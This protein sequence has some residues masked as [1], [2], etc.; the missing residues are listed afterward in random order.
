MSLRKKTAQGLLFAMGDTLVGRMLNIITSIVL[1]RLIAPDQFGI[2]AIIMVFQAFYQLLIDAGFGQALIQ[3][4]NVTQEDLNAVFYFNVIMGLLLSLALYSSAPLI[5]RFY[6]NE[7]LRPALRVI[8]ASFLAISFRSVQSTMIIRNLQ[9]GKTMIVSTSS[10]IVSSIVSI[11]LAFQG[12]DV[13]ALVW[14]GIAGT[15]TRTVMLTF[16]GRWKPTFSFH[17]ASLRGL[18]GFS[19]KMLLLTFVGQLAEQMYSLVIGKLYPAATLGFYARARNLRQMSIN[20]FAQPLNV[21]MF[22]GFAKLQHEPEKLRKV[23]Y[24]S[25]DGAMML[26][27]PL[28]LGLGAVSEQVIPLLYGERW[29]AAAQYFSV[30]C[31]A[32]VFV[33]MTNLRSS[34]IK[35]LGR[36]GLRF[37]HEIIVSALTLLMIG[38]VAPFGVIALVWTAVAQGCISPLVLALISRKLWKIDLYAELRIVTRTIAFGVVMYFGVKTLP[39]LLPDMGIASLLMLEFITGAGI[40]TLLCRIFATRSLYQLLRS[41]EGGLPDKVLAVVRNV[42]ILPS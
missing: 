17:Y 18:F 23:F 13:W 24:E 31:W 11:M 14:G 8:S 3:K 41:L 5:A 9:F 42:L 4:K 25:M 40:Y 15:M 6:G 7:V 33:P 10:T 16:I 19:S 34:L 21:V 30:L 36:P 38:L 32:I 39:R 28:A 35:A 26:F 27:V 29:M 22:P 37:M 1:A 2:M 20:S 12:M